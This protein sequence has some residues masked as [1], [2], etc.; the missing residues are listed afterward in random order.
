MIHEF[1]RLHGVCID[2]WELVPDVMMFLPMPWIGSFVVTAVQQH[3]MQSRAAE[4]H[5]TPGESR[6]IESTCWAELTTIEEVSSV[7]VILQDWPVV[8]AGLAGLEEQLKGG[9]EFIWVVSHSE[10]DCD[11]VDEAWKQAKLVEIGDIIVAQVGCNDVIVF[12]MV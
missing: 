7:A 5:R 4:V 1:R 8:T 12:G 2:L 3:L 10:V 11:L 6:H 9:Q